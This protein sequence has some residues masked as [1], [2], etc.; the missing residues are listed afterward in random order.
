MTVEQC[1]ASDFR[2]IQELDVLIELLCN[3]DLDSFV[4]RDVIFFRVF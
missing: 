2:L 1:E 3:G 4:F